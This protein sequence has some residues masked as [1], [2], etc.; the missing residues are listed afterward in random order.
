MQEQF[1]KIGNLFHQLADAFID[2]ANTTS[3]PITPPTTPPDPP[4]LLDG[5]IGRW[6]D[7]MRVGVIRTHNRP[8]APNLQNGVRYALT[9]L[10]TTRDGNWEPSNA[11]GSVDTW[12][13]EKYLKPLGHPAY[14]DDAG[15]ATHLFAA[16]IGL[17]GQLLRGQQIV[18]WSDGLAKLA[19]VTYQGYITQ[20][21]KE[22]SGWANL[23]LSPSSNYIPDR[24]ETGPWCWCPSGAADV[25]VGGGLPANQHV[26]IFAVWQAVLMEKRP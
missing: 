5:R 22:R 19:D 11:F 16:I 2:L 18:F 14:F 12:A 6:I 9:D 17:D 25:V 20:Y 3:S 24:G 13:R 1:L 21:T 23:P 7:P 15:G 4:T 26:S 8:D 10:F